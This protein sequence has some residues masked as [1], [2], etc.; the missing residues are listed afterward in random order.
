MHDPHAHTCMQI[1]RLRRASGESPGVAPKTAINNLFRD[2]HAWLVPRDLVGRSTLHALGVDEEG[3]GHYD[4][5][6]T[7]S[8]RVLGQWLSSLLAVLSR[9][10]RA[11]LLSTLFAPSG[12]TP[13]S[14]APRTSHLLGQYFTSANNVD[15]IIREAGQVLR[16]WSHPSGYIFVEPSCGD[17][18]VLQAAITA[19]GKQSRPSESGSSNAFVGVDL[20]PHCIARAQTLLADN[21][22]SPVL[23]T[24][25]FLG[26]S[27]DALDAVLGGNDTRPVVVLGNPPYTLHPTPAPTSTLTPTPSPPPS[28]LLPAHFIRH[29]ILNLLASVIIFVLPSRLSSLTPTSLPGLSAETAAQWRVRC[30]TAEE[31]VDH[32]FETPVSP[33][34]CGDGHATRRVKQPSCIQ[35]WTRRP[36]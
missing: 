35:I 29:S 19:F 32:V 6:L 21:S 27:A 3:V 25:D 8:I 15:I 9:H 10:G 13:H 5:V 2:R 7:K 34:G 11:D 14:S 33:S 1:Q 26:V 12:A 31:G 23:M 4:Q 17:G 16:N 36:S 20:D 22:P 24:R 28:S 18:R 30:L